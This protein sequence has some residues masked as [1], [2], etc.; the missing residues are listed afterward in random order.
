MT[1]PADRAGERPGGGQY[2][3]ADPAV[4][5]AR[6]EVVLVLP[7][8]ELRLLTDRGVFSATAVD[9]GTQILLRSV[10]GQPVGSEIVDVG[11][12][13][14]PIAVAVARRAPTARV[15]A[16]DV[17]QRALELTRL[18][19]ERVGA[20]RV[21]PVRPEEV[22][23][24][25]RVDTIYSNPPIRVGK[26]ALHELLDFWLSRLTPAGTAYLVVQKHLGADSLA[27]W[28][29]EQGHPTDRI[30]ARESF[31]VLRVGPRAAAQ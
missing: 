10:P 19:A 13:Y 26:A 15:W 27:R 25:L 18:N 14:G 11:C 17:N 8:G 2:F 12:G 4:G 24:D 22:P 1:S 21:V 16:V 6:R 30:A 20:G 3:A 28:L 7:E 23:V 5:S 31:R 9:R 29:R